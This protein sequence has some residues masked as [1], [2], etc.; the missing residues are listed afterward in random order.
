MQQWPRG[1]GRNSEIDRLANRGMEEQQ[2]DF[3]L[4]VKLFFK[5]VTAPLWLPFWLWAKY[6][7]RK[8]A[9][10]EASAGSPQGLL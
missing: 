4:A 6:R 3:V 9:K 7:K 5:L 1:W 8:K 2:H 10:A